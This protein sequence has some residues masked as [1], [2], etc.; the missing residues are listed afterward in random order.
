M[1]QL[2]FGPTEAQPLKDGQLPFRMELPEVVRRKAEYANH[3]MLV[4]I[5]ALE[6]QVC[7]P[8]TEFLGLA[9]YV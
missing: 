7:D 3:F 1:H 5:A 8:V 4:G 9:D 6:L 2:D